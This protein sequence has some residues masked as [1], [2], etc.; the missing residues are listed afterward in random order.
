MFPAAILRIDQPVFAPK[1]DRWVAVGLLFAVLLWGAN[2]VVT[3]LL[4][5]GW[6]PLW[7]GSTRFACAGLLLLSLL[8]WSSG[9]G[10]RTPITPELSRILWIRGALSLALY[11]TVFNCAL[12]LTSPAHLALYLGASPIWSLVFESRPRGGHG[13]RRRY[14][15]ASLAMAGVLVLFWPVLRSGRSQMLGELLALLAGILWTLYS[16]QSRFLAAKLSG[17]EVTAHTMWRAAV[18]LAPLALVESGLALPT[19]DITLIGIQ[20][21]AVFGG[22]VMAF[23][24]WNNALQVWPAS[25]VF[26]FGNFIP[27]VTMLWAWFLLGE[28]LTATFGAATVLILSGAL[29]G[30]LKPE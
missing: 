18:V 15:A 14:L 20:A 2:N 10:K 24:L 12:Q 7:I 30:Q 28:P 3:K 1:S 4:L 8:R 25:R 23:T 17:V 11:I 16:H 27:P 5:K 19:M 9:L 26:L 13:F 22:G 6:P 21:Y 29:L